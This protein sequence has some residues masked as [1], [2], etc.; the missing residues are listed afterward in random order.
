MTKI[1]IQAFELTTSWL[2]GHAAYLYLGDVAA[3]VQFSER[4]LPKTDISGS[5]PVISN[6]Y[7]IY[8]LLTLQKAYFKI[9]STFDNVAMTKNIIES[10]DQYCKT[11]FAVT[12]LMAT[13]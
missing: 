3:V 7:N 1:S 8:S 11:E 2:C 13:F 10:W 5:N 12:Q 9:L 4:S 6:F